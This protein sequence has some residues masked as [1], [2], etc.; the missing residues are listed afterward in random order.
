MILAERGT[1]MAV[2]TDV[3]VYTRVKM[4]SVHIDSKKTYCILHVV[5]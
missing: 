2:G 3:V 4:F 1:D 5:I